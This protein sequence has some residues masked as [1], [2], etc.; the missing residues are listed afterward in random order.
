MSRT[1]IHDS[2]LFG[3]T[4]LH[5]RIRRSSERRTLEIT[6]GQGQVTVAA[7]AGMRAS[8]IRPLI[9]KR[10]AWI[11]AKLDD[12]RRQTKQWPRRL[13]S[14]ETISYLG[15]QYQLKVIRPTSHHSS[16]L[17]FGAG[18]FVLS[19]PAQLSLE[20][21]RT[22]GR[23][24]FRL[25]FQS[26]LEPKVRSFAWRHAKAL[27]LAPPPCHVRELGGRWGSCRPGKGLLFHWQLAAASP[28]VIDFVAA[29]EVCHLL[30]PNHNPAFF[31]LLSR[32]VPDWEML[33]QQLSR[34]RQLD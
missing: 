27:N 11:V 34:A 26:H 20:D 4:T 25:W 30:Q 16:Q 9:E 15:R 13:V 23:K 19:L 31:R 22:E 3:A 7:P 2:I 24:L 17:T 1:I 32:L 21:C 12:D 28:R 33:E 14:G 6:V 29:H 10:A 18:S 8:A 5:Y